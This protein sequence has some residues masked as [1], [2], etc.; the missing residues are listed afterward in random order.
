MNSNRRALV[1]EVVGERK[2]IKG[3]LRSPGRVYYAFRRVAHSVQ[4]GAEFLCFLCRYDQAP[5]PLQ[6]PACHPC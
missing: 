3:L 2:K 4:T 6:V 5:N 1:F